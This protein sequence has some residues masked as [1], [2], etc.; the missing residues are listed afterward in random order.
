MRITKKVK[1]NLENFV[2]KI[3][4]I[5]FELEFHKSVLWNVWYL[6]D[7]VDIRHEI[8]D[9][10]WN[11]YEA[12][13]RESARSWLPK[14]E[15]IKDELEKYQKMNYWIANDNAWSCHLHFFTTIND[16]ERVS[17]NIIRWLLNLTYKWNL[18][19]HL[20][21]RHKLWD[22]EYWNKTTAINIEETKIGKDFEFRIN[23]MI[24]D[25]EIVS[26]YITILWLAYKGIMFQIN[27]EVFF[28][29][30]IIKIKMKYIPQI[31]PSKF[32]PFERW[33]LLFGMLFHKEHKENYKVLLP[34]IK[35]VEK[36]LKQ[37]KPN[38]FELLI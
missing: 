10:V 5:G 32:Q 28:D 21:N 16:E 22:I 15:K 4:D 27:D 19:W 1:E 38:K 11:Q 14:I 36:L 20:E 31:N 35:E 2:N 13:N 6:L 26:Y 23:E 9:E 24:P 33:R 25:Y 12:K 37:K 8:D 3:F 7:N 30:N 17:L 18:R 34:F 29:N